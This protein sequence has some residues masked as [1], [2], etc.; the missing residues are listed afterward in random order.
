MSDQSIAKAIKRIASMNDS[1]LK[2][3]YGTI[4]KV[5]PRTD[6]DMANIDFVSRDENVILRDIPLSSVSEDLT[7]VYQEPTIDSLVTLLWHE[8]TN[9]AIVLA[10]SHVKCVDITAD[11]LAKI[12]VTDPVSGD[13]SQTEY[14][15]EA[16]KHTIQKGDKSLLVAQ[17]A[18]SSSSIIGKTLVTQNEER[19]T[20]S[21]EGASQEVGKDSISLNAPTISL[22]EKAE[23]P[24]VLGRQLAELMKDFL[25]ECSKITTPTMLG[26]MPITNMMN[27]TALMGKINNFLSKTVKLE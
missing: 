17:N 25:T 4:T 16:I 5:I 15:S 2:I 14:T 23:E 10:Y 19:V 3:L 22:G 6:R 1:P 9:K 12:G 7:G 26:T 11:Q 21:T 20:V 13:F 24:A 8:N 18:E 27:F